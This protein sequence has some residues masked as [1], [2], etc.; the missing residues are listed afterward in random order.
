M[1]HE[2]NRFIIHSS[3]TVDLKKI[4][5]KK[6][7]S[8][9]KDLFKKSIKYNQ[10]NLFIQTPVL[11][12]PFDI[13][14]YN[15]L[16]VS[17]LNLDKDMEIK[18]FYDLVNSISNKIL[19]LKSLKDKTFIS[20]IKSKN[21]IF[22]ER[23]RLNIINRKII[24]LY[25]DSNE[26]ITF[27]ELKE[28]TYAKFIICP[29]DIWI[30]TNKFGINWNIIQIKMYFRTDYFP[31]ELVFLEDDTNINNN[32][33]YDKYFKMLKRGVPKDA[34]KQ[35]L[36]LDNLDP[37]I[38]DNPKSCNTKVKTNPNISKNTSLLS[39]IKLGI[40]F[41]ATETNKKKDKSTIKYETGFVPSLNDIRDI[42]KK[43]KYI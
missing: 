41:K 16:D 6:N 13:N 31:K 10:N 42:L 28:K 21:S 32:N 5:F 1:I 18:L 15:K 37:S 12:I 9:S 19:N 35:K 20:S 24:K 4:T 14:T 29:K 11:Y 26:Q 27:N 40:K 39:E 8:F 36:I 2:S 43:M 7:I 25:N 38:I 17:F 23:L 30:T 3:D 22:P 33:I 34:I